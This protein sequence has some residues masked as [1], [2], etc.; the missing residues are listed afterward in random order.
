V[1]NTIF[2]INIESTQNYSFLLWHESD[3]W[4]FE[5]QIFVCSALVLFYDMN[6]LSTLPKLHGHLRYWPVIMV[7]VQLDWPLSSLTGQ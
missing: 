5:L 1:K 7:N 4:Y 6:E 3:P 2:S